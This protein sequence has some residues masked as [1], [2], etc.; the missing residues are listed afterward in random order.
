MLTQRKVALVDIGSKN[1]SVFVGSVGGNKI[2][3]MSSGAEC[4]YDGY[5][6]GEWIEPAKVLSVA[7]H[8]MNKAL[9][10]I[11]GKPSVIYVSVPSQFCKIGLGTANVEFDARRKITDMDLSELISKCGV[12]EVS[13]Y[14]FLDSAP[15]QYV[16]DGSIKTISPVGREAGKL[17]VKASFM[18]AN[19]DFCSLF[20]DAF[21]DYSK[22]IKFVCSA[23]A[24]TK[25]L[26]DSKIREQGVIL[27]DI[28][29][30]NTDIVQF[31]G[32]G[33]LSLSTI[34]MGG[35]HIAYDISCGANIPF[36]TAGYVKG[37]LDFTPGE[38]K[39]EYIDV[40]TDDGKKKLKVD[41][42]EFIAQSRLEDIAESVL[43]KLENSSNKFPEYYKIYVTG[44][45]VSSVKG[46]KYV[47]E[48]ALKRASDIIDSNVY[49]FEKNTSGAMTGL[50]YI[51]ENDDSQGVVN[52]FSNLLK[53][54]SVMINRK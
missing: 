3:N 14:R 48:P 36:D 23:W 18:Y 1:I 35:G 45:G 34:S 13:G 12:A 22:N 51:A 21:S 29:Y 31:M 53:K 50:A 33:I 7:K 32:E 9:Y 17:E 46:V 27:C 2:F 4:S 54:V 15:L 49:G 52:V 44:E 40:V 16:V 11:K 38:R 43:A 25:A 42:I 8:V 19:K 5:L 6:D 10:D 28:G 26:F 47:I 30:I 20:E 39:K 41:F 24:E 37:Q